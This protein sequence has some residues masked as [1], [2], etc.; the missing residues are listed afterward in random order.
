MVV[1]RQVYMVMEYFDNDLKHVLD[2][3]PQLL[4]EGDKKWLMLQLLRGV[5]YMHQR[6]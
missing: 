2:T 3:V 5:E 1:E 4:K 6:W